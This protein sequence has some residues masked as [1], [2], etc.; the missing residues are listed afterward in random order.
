[1]LSSNLFE[2]VLIEPAKKGCDKLLI[3]SGYASATMASYHL[4]QLKEKRIKNIEI[5]LIIG[6]IP[7][8]GISNR[9]HNGFKQIM[10]NDYAKKFE[11]SYRVSQPPVHSKVYAWLKNNKPVS[12]FI[13]SA[14]Y[15]QMA[16]NEL[17][18]KEALSE[19]PAKQGFDYYTEMIDDS[20]Y[21]THE[22]AE[23]YVYIHE[24]KLFRRRIR[25]IKELDL[26]ESKRSTVEAPA[27]R[28]TISLLKK[29]GTMY[30]PGGGL[31]WGTSRKRNN[32]NEAYI[33]LRPDV[34][35]SNFF[36]PK[37]LHFTVITDDDKTLI[38]TRVSKDAFGQ[39][40]ETPQN[41]GL[42]GEYFRNRLGLANGAFVKK[43]DLLRYGRTDVTFYKIDDENYFMD[44][45]V[46][47]G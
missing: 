39:Q 1:M 9:N 12:A 7:V 30:N 10:T 18:Q 28:V 26:A 27:Q 4:E 47:N 35:K 16:F 23:S 6:M 11:C 24:E 34:Y 20:I 29:D 3:I 43:E 42:L 46:N 36:P 5:K 40:I 25:G 41:N 17:K 45:S 31:N 19:F 21:C 44:F 33:Q 8:D 22:E 32:R 2:K 15:T 14:N 38:C 13:G 37:P